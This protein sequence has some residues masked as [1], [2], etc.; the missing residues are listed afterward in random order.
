MKSSP[1]TVTTAIKLR[2]SW[3]FP[4]QCVSF[5][6]TTK[7][8]SSQNVNKFLI[9]KWAQK[10]AWEGCLQKSGGCGNNVNCFWLNC[11]LEDAL[12]NQLTSFSL[13][14]FCSHISLCYTVIAS[15][16]VINKYVNKL[17]L[18]MSGCILVHQNFVSMGCKNLAS[19]TVEEQ[20]GVSTSVIITSFLWVVYSTEE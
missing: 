2:I 9:Q 16:T 1:C 3:L 6:K 19:L 10:F 14:Y 18:H 20:T 15:Y 7:P 13:P 17:A 12:L 5:C 11:R 4:P 8:V